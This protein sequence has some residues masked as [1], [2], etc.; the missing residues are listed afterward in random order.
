[1]AGVVRFAPGAHT[2]WHRHLNGQTL[3]TLDGRGLVQA[4]GGQVIEVGPGDTIET[5]PGEWHR[6]GAVQDQT[7][8]GPGRRPAR[9]VTERGDL[10]GGE[11][12]GR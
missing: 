8:L 2:A 9:P 10:T 3:H 7:H 5:P 12:P 6:H 1:V 4:R 11:Y